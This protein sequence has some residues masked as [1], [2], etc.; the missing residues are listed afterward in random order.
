M[1]A[2]INL[3]GRVRQVTVQRK[4]RGATVAS[5]SSDNSAQHAV[6]TVLTVPGAGVRTNGLTP[7]GEGVRTVKHLKKEVLEQSVLTAVN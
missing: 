6:G 2:E 1:G 5:Y 3:S 7:P 4:C